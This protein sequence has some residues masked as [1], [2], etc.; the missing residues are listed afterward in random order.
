ME[1]ITTD[2][3]QMVF[4]WEK[5]Y[6]NGKPPRLIIPV[7]FYHGAD[8]WKVPRSFAE[9]FHVD[10]EIKKY[11]LDYRYILFD[12]NPWDFRD[13]SNKEL[14]DNVFLFTAMVLLKAAFKNDL[15]AIKEIFHFWHQKGFTDNKDVA[16]FFMQYISQT[17]DVNHDQLKEILDKSKI[18]GGVIMPTLAQRYR[19]QFREEYEEEFMKNI[20]PL[21]REEGIKKKAKED[22]IKMLRRGFDFD[23]IMDIT[24]LSQSE[25]EELNKSITH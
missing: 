8:K 22:A 2:I 1:N 14:K 19:E 16:L 13:E 21:L 23:M 24:G 12:T 20:G 18:D 11:L 3:Q 7:V 10:K 4:E 25:I 17:Q 5:D 9:Q 6:N 15:E